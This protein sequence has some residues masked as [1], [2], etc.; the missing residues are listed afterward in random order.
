MMKPA[1]LSNVLRERRADWIIFW[2]ASAVNVGHCRANANH[3]SESI[4]GFVSGNQSGRFDCAAAHETISGVGGGAS[5]AATDLPAARLRATRNADCARDFAVSLLCSSN[6]GT[7]KPS[8]VTANQP[9]RTHAAANPLM[10]TCAFNQSAEYPGR[11]PSVVCVSAKA[12][13]AKQPPTACNG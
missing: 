11:L 7:C 10:P 12:H 13:N 9:T 3:V 6:R 8:S 2:N 5:I 1:G 4:H